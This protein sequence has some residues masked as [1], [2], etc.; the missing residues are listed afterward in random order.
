MHVET[1]KQGLVFY[2]CVI[3]VV[4]LYW[5]ALTI[6]YMLLIVSRDSDSCSFC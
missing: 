4:E 1:L 3:D 2:S 6:C 5:Y